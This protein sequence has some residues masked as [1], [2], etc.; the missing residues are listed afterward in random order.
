MNYKNYKTL[1]LIIWKVY[2]SKLKEFRNR[3]ECPRQCM[4]LTECFRRTYA[5]RAVVN[6]ELGSSNKNTEKIETYST[7]AE[8]DKYICNTVFGAYKR[9]RTFERPNIRNIIM[10]IKH[11]IWI[12]MLGTRPQWR[13]VVK[14][15]INRRIPKETGQFQFSAQKMASEGLSSMG[16]ATMRPQAIVSPFLSKKKTTSVKVW[17]LS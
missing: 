14:K 15:V 12:C 5:Y 2:I 6:F 17:C 8:D 10:N 1:Y 16:L 3:V 9:K 11:R 13:T 4:V 7:W